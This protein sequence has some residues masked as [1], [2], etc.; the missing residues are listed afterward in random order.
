[1][2]FVATAS[3]ICLAAIS[4]TAIA[5]SQTGPQQPNLGLPASNDALSHVTPPP[6]PPPK[7]PS[8]TPNP[9]QSIQ[10]S[11]GLKP[12]PHVGATIPQTFTKP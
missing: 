8:D 5:Q 1:M 12:V 11:G 2:R 6:S 4:G 7:P 3:A 10:P 9:P